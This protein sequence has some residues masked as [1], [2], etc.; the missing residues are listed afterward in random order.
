MLRTGSRASHTPRS[1]SPRPGTA[2]VFDL[3]LL[4][5][6]S[7]RT[8]RMLAARANHTR[9]RVDPSLGLQ[10]TTLH[11]RC[12]AVSIRLRRT[13]LEYSLVAALIFGIPE[14]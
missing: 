4:T 7:Y 9:R 2:A 5:V 14:R 13:R 8:R 1:R 10:R 3:L 11:A 12:L 6:V